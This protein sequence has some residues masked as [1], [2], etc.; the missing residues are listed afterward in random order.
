MN[1][2]AKQVVDSEYV[3]LAAR[4]MI[5]LSVPTFG[6]LGYLFQAILSDIRADVKLARDAS[7]G[8][9]TE[10]AKLSADMSGDR[11]LAVV[12]AEL[13]EKY[14][15]WEVEE[16]ARLSARMDRI[17]ERLNAAPPRR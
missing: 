16:Y 14:H 17:E 7:W 3:T 8:N 4:V 1:G 5:L 2:V 10:I 12:A 9:G 13:V 11:R 6:V 15:R